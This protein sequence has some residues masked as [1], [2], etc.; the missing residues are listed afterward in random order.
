MMWFCDSVWRGCHHLLVILVLKFASSLKRLDQGQTVHLATEALHGSDVK[1][2]GCAGIMSCMWMKLFKLRSGNTTE[3]SLS[4]CLHKTDFVFIASSNFQ[5]TVSRPYRQVFTGFW[6]FWFKLRTHAYQAWPMLRLLRLV[7]HANHRIC[8][9][10]NSAPL[11]GQLGNGIYLWLPW[12]MNLPKR[13]MMS[14]CQNH[15]PFSLERNM[16][17]PFSTELWTIGSCQVTSSGFAGRDTWN[18]EMLRWRLPPAIRL[19]L[20]CPCLRI[21]AS[22]SAYRRCEQ[23]P[24]HA[25]LSD[26][27]HK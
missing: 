9:M 12:S 16:G 1:V 27:S 6:H 3:F 23:W 21:Q 24:S 22:R 10:S 19:C 25:D 26:R 11:H 14:N 13:S 7:W 5:N 17:R 8:T 4:S 2:Y 15:I 18:Y 20:P